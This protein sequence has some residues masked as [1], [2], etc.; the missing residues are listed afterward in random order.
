MQTWRWLYK[1]G[2]PF[3]RRFVARVLVKTALLFVAL[4]VAFV[5][6]D[7]LPALGRLSLY[8]H[9]LPGRA[10]LPYGENPDA[11]Y[12]LSLFSLEAMFASHEATRA[13]AGDEFR[14]LLL[15]DSATWGILLRPDETLA[16]QINAVGLVAADGRRVRAYNLGYPT[17]S[18]TKDL[19]LLDFALPHYEPDL[20][21][22]LFTLESFDAQTQLDSPLVAHNPA[23]VR[24]LI[25]RYGL[26]QDPADPR[27]VDPS[28][29]DRT[30][31][32]RRRALADLLR[33][34]LY[35]VP[36]AV[37]GIDQEYPADYI[38]RAVDLPAD[39][40][41]HGLREDLFAPADLAFDV[42]RAGV[43]RA[44]D[45]PLLLVNEPMLISTG[46]NSDIRYNF[47]YPRWAYDAY[48]QL[49]YAERD[50]HGWA[51]LDLGATIPDADCYTDSAVHLTPACAAE[52][53][54]TV[55]AAIVG[56]GGG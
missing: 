6:L 22:W 44:G 42:L 36:W 49:L 55:G 7:P 19:L 13:P 35:G 48:Q 1:P 38:P 52:L 29:W 17:M 9:V 51:L 28:T 24:A 12:N 5:L 37:T 43:A 39:A 46:A 4:N 10:R 25:E 30:L 31:I 45:V 41:W 16:G 27:F 34:Q 14:V 23:P 26:A 21:V 54:E 53:A 47:F 50:A 3:D 15:G 2:K 8:S 32:G 11:A 40:T 33:L 18:L 20:V 56:A